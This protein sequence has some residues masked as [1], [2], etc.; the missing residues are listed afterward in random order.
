MRKLSDYKDEEA[1]ELWA[2]LLDPISE[3]FTDKEVAEVVNSNVNRLTLARTMLKTH[4]KEV[5]AILERIDPEPVTGLNIVIRLTNILAEI[6]QNPEIA[7]F[8]GFAGRAMTPKE[9]SGL[10]T[11]SIEE[12]D[13]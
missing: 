6:G 5:K 1:I 12:S 10:P 13:E 2:D 4:S 9:S 3:I 11:E 7:A 8:F